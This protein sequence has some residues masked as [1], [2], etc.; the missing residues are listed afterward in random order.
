DFARWRGHEVRIEMETPV[1]TGEGG[2]GRKRFRGVIMGVEDDAALIAR[3]ATG[4][5]EPAADRL[6][7]ADMREARLVLTDAL[8]D[9]ALGRTGGPQ[10]K[11]GGARRKDARARKK[12]GE[13]PAAEDDSGARDSR[14]DEKHG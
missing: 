9:A 14:R 1:E 6:P 12:A 13:T 2:G 5:E 4:G 11:S 8:I 7:I 3:D 10:K